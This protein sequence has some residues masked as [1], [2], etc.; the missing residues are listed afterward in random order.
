MVFDRNKEK[1]VFD[2]KQKFWILFD[3]SGENDTDKIYERKIP[4]KN[5]L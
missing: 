3:Y 2:I 1:M 5:N 4:W